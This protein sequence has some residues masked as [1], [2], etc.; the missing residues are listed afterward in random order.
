MGISGLL[1]LLKS[2]HRPADLKKYAGETLGIDGYGWLHRGAI[3]CAMELAQG[4]PTRK[5]VDFAM[6]RV[7]MFKHFGVTPYFVFDGDYLPSKAGTE[8]SRES[9]REACRSAGLE[10]VK[11]GKPAQAYQELQKAID[12]TPEMARHLIEDLKKANV[13][14]VVA[15][16]EADAQLVYLE[17]KGIIHGIV[18]EDS[19][20]LVF[21]AKRLLT[22]MDEHGQCVE[23]NRKDFCLVRNV[24]LTGWSDMEFRHM[25]ILSGCDYLPGVKGMGLK[26]AHRMIRQHKTPERITKRLQFDGKDVP[27]NYLADFK[28]AELTFLYQRVFCPK[29]RDIVFLTE[30]DPTVDVEAMPFIGAPVETELARAIAAGDINPITKKSIIVPLSPGK[31]RISQLSVP[32]QAAKKSL[33]KPINEYFGS[34]RIPL[35]EMDPNCFATKPHENT[36]I[37]VEV[38]RPIVFPLPRPYLDDAGSTAGP[39]RS[40]TNRTHRRR[41]IPIAEQLASLGEVTSRERRHTAGPTIQIYQDSSSSARPPKKA[42]LCEDLPVELATK[43]T[44]ERSKFFAAQPKKSKSKSVDQFL[45][46]DDSI[47]EVFRNLPDFESHQPGQPAQTGDAVHIVDETPDSQDGTGLDH[48]GPAMG[49]EG[50]LASDDVEVPASSPLAP[51]RRPLASK[52]VSSTPLSARLQQ[53]SYNS[54]T[55]PATRIVHGLP[56]PSSST[57]KSSSPRSTPLGNAQPTRLTPLQHIGAQ[58]L[59]RDRTRPNPPSPRA[60]SSGKGDRKFGSQPINP[61]FVPLPKVDLAEIE[62]L[63]SLGGSED[64]IIP[65][66]D[67]EDNLED[68]E[69][70]QGVL[71]AEKRS[72]SLGGLDLSRFLYG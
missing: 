31:R 39:A 23:I 50:T 37:P 66:S 52:R 56:T 59:K 36:G 72:A 10:L 2:I 69:D 43:C 34:R 25:A 60:S 26:T 27:A 14:Y 67:G 16:Y 13:P 65:E 61:A 18:S 46:S 8:S 45:M 64:Q 1:P 5:Y 68:P 54:F 62:A 3:S 47:D 44:P 15:P 35:G 7:R 24:S 28:K 58:A 42:R 11:A 17:R 19:D 4:R 55:R 53:F 71:A 29:K 49:N 70:G 30:P 20:L 57:E 40:Y 51:P 41:T 22:K 6:H 9:R 32:V 33:G 38:P 12:I 48:E 21:G 63:N